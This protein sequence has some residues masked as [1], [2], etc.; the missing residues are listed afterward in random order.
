MLHWETDHS[1]HNCDPSSSS[2]SV[3]RVRLGKAFF[4]GGLATDTLSGGCGPHEVQV[5]CQVPGKWDHA[6]HWSTPGIAIRSSEP[7]QLNKSMMSMPPRPPLCL[8][9]HRPASQVSIRS[10]V[11]PRPFLFVL[12]IQPVP[13]LIERSSLLAASS[14]V[15]SNQLGAFAY[16]C[17]PR[18]P[19]PFRLVHVQGL[20]IRSTI[21]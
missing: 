21:A 5:A 19:R 1:I 20:C 16:P 15:S 7:Q 8:L 18:V 17:M 11:L 13:R 4:L 2:Q 14:P 12:A 6:I 3:S 9:S 10:E